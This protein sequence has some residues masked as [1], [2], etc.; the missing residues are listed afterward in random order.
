MATLQ[1]AQ[2]FDTL[3]TLPYNNASI[4]FKKKEAN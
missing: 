2:Q 1:T 3:W 4:F